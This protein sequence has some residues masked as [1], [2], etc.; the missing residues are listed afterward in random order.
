[1]DVQVSQLYANTNSFRDRVRNDTAALCLGV[2][3]V[4][5]RALCGEVYGDNNSFYSYQGCM[6]EVFSPPILLPSLV[7]EHTFFFITRKPKGPNLLPSNL[8]SFSSLR[9][10][11]QE[12]TSCLNSS[13]DSSLFHCQ[14]VL[15]SYVQMKSVSW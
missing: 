6:K 14:T 2:L 4:V 13:R 5:W 12:E 3:A 1:M 11:S 9:V 8:G 7:V 15:F 10:S